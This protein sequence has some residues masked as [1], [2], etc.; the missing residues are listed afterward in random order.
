MAT[1]LTRIGHG[2]QV[3]LHLS[4][5]LA[6]GTEVVSTFDDEP[7]NF[8]MGDGTLREGMEMA[9]FG[10]RPGDE[11]SILLDAEHA[12]GERLEGMVQPL[13]R[14]AFPDDMPLEPGSIVTFDSEEDQDL[15]GTVLEINDTQVLVDFNH[16]LAGYELMFRVQVLEVENESN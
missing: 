4:L 9:L 6:D 12:Y 11:Q 5:T 16:P 7:I 2:S 1:Q 15:P 3:S 10:L 13:P 14:E 8:Q